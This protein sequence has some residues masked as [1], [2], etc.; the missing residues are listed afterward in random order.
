MPYTEAEQIV[1]ATRGKGQPTWFW[2]FNDKGRVF[3]KKTNSDYVGA[4]SMRFW[5]EHLLGGKHVVT[6]DTGQHT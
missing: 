5:E 6:M 4:A 3:R 2:M 1:K